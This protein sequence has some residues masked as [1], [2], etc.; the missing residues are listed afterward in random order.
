VLRELGLAAEP[1]ALGLGGFHAVFAT[2]QEPTTF[3][4]TKDVVGGFYAAFFLPSDQALASFCRQ[5]PVS[6]AP[7]VSD[8][9]RIVVDVTF[10]A[11]RGHQGNRLATYAA[12]DLPEHGYPFAGDETPDLAPL[13]NDNLGT[14]HITLKLAV[15]LDFALTDNLHALASKL[16]VILDHHARLIR[17]DS[18]PSCWANEV[19]R[20]PQDR[21]PGNVHPS[22]LRRWISRA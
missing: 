16:E 21:R 11:R 6:S 7:L 15:D 1:D 9:Q 12:D 4:L 2:L 19:H 17:H 3:V 13:T 10:H 8:G 5:R 22:R 18:H 20:S 14:G